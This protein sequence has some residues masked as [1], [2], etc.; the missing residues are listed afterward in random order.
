MEDSK[1]PALVLN[2]QVLTEDPIELFSQ[3]FKFAHE[4]SGYNDTNAMCLSTIDNEGFPDSRMVLLKS[5]S[6]DG[7][8][9]FTNSLS[10]KGK[11]LRQVPRAA[12]NFHWDTLR[13]QIRI[14]GN[15]EPVSSE[16]ADSYFHSRSRRSQ[17]GAAVSK[18]SEIL[19]SREKLEQQVSALET[20]LSGAEVPRPD[21]WIGYRVQP[22]RIEFWRDGA[23]RLHD[24]FEYKRTGDAWSVARLYP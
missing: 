17:I 11:A 8:V 1:T 24:R 6:K 23:N 21:H 20:E 9:F 2:E 7:F 14:Q 10:R 15:I 4:H 3:W 13:I 18:Q 5:F 19:E 22:T 16:E 12:L